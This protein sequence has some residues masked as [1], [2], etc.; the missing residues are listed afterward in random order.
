M[1]SLRQVLS[2][3]LSKRDLALLRAGFDVVGDIAIIEVPF[4]LK[5]K[6]KIIADALFKLVKNVNTVACKLGPH[7]GKFRRQKLEVLAG[8][9]NFITT[10][11]ESG[12][13][14]RL[15]VEKCYFSPRL[16]SERLRAAKLI[17][18][19]E[20]VF[21]ACSGVA[22][23]PIVF[24]K[25]SRAKRIVALE[26][27]PVAH[28]FALENIRLN[29]VQ[30]KV[31]AFKG[32]VKKAFEIVHEKFDRLFL[33]APKEGSSLLPPLLKLAKKGA[34]FHVYDFASEGAFSEVAERV[35]LA[36]EKVKKKCEILGVVKCGQHAPRV[37]RVRV[38]ARLV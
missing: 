11:K 6:K 21:V 34:F 3:K 1:S 13:L 2:K 8:V 37:F 25:H 26:L 15:D 7:F 17:K 10:H 23:F 28:K 19:G 20:S 27:N 30:D 4:E 14:F 38:D 24:A 12:C 32:D 29:K 31:K 35:R 36:C 5:K 22:P 9:K 16:G 18:P 33:P